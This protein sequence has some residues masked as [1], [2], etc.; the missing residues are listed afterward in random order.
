MDK[1]EIIKWIVIS[2]LAFLVIVLTFPVASL[3]CYKTQDVC[4]VTNKALLGGE[5]VAARF[6]ISEIITSHV[7]SKDG[8]YYPTLTDER[9]EVY[10]LEAFPT[11]TYHRSEEIIQHILNDEKYEIIGSFSKLINKGY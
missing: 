8:F 6:R 7:R 4:T 11:K 3:S 5:Q 10:M 1:K 9:R 2:A